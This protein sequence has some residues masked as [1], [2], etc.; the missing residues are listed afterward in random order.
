MT[1]GK[2]DE[3]L[4]VLREN[5]ELSNETQ[6]RLVFHVLEALDA[7]TRNLEDARKKKERRP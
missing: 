7:R 2:V 3:L 6:M 1:Q 5:P 4:A